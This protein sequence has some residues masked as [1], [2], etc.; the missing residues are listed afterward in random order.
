MNGTWLK[1]VDKDKDLGIVFRSNLK[2]LEQCMRLEAADKMLIINC[3]L[4]YWS[5]EVVKRIY[6]SLVI[7]LI[8]YYLRLENSP[9]MNFDRLEAI[10]HRLICGFGK[11][12]WDEI[13]KKLNMFSVEI[14][15][16]GNMI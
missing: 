15:F 14:F 9:K 10:Q 3:N 4:A 16:R 11:K 2:L 12:L 7:P 6:N 13:G 1:S 5:K 8:E